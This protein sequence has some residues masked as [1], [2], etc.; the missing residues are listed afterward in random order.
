MEGLQNSN[1]KTFPVRRMTEFNETT[2][3]FKLEVKNNDA[4]ASAMSHTSYFK[5]FLCND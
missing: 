2:A 3:Q 1:E 5:G 4:D